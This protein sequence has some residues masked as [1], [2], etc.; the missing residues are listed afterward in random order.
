MDKDRLI[1]FAVSYLESKKI[2][3]TFDKIVATAFKLFPK[4][5]SLI[6]FPEYPDGKTIY[7]CVYNHCTLTKKWLFGNVQSAFKITDR[8]KYFLDETIKMLEGKIE[9]ARTHQTSPR[10]KEITFIGENMEFLINENTWQEYKRK[11]KAAYGVYYTTLQKH[12][13]SWYLSKPNANKDNS[14]KLKDLIGAMP[15]P[16][17]I[18]VPTIIV[19]GIW[20]TCWNYEWFYWC[21]KDG[22]TPKEE[23]QTASHDLRL[24]TYGNRD[25]VLRP[26]IESVWNGAKFAD[27][28]GKI[29]GKYNP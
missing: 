29:I 3:P 11:L 12:G 10:R 20:A 18:D 15:N 16:E 25:P 5:F 24:L 13:L 6:G 22:Q 26:L 14:D 2:E 23:A 19:M 27:E 9:L 28:I 4:K 7:H 21:G 1:L 17:E 8:G